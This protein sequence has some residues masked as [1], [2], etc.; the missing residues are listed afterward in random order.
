MLKGSVDRS[1]R[2]TRLFML[3]ARPSRFVGANA[4]SPRQFVSESGRN[5][6]EQWFHLEAIQRPRHAPGNGEDVLQT[7]HAH[8]K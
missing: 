6:I 1:L 4:L 7:Q 3:Q 5:V 2:K 8:P